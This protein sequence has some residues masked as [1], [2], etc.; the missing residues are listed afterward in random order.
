MSI[1]S[2][3]LLSRLN[4]QAKGNTSNANGTTASDYTANIAQDNESAWA[5]LPRLQRAIMELVAKD[6]T[7]EGLHV[8][9]ISRGVSGN[10][11]HK[12]EDVM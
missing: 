3:T 10:G 11:E 4:P 7:D 5:A 1:P 9:V 8:S 6:D 2:S 12:G